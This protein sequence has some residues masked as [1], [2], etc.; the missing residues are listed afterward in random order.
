MRSKGSPGELEHRRRLAVQRVVEGYSAEEVADFLGVDIRSVRRWVAVFR[1]HGW[2]G[3]EAQPISGRPRKLTRTQEKIVLRWLDDKPTDHG[4]A[5]ELWT[6]PRLAQL[7]QEEWSIEL[8]PWSVCRW[9]RR[10]GLSLQKPQRVPRE[11]DP[12]VIAA[13]L[14]TEWPRIKKKRAGATPTSS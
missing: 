11:R 9:L 7:I 8:H 10:H 6:A 2:A 3:L 13:W 4:F 5:T 14:A 12:A 1:R